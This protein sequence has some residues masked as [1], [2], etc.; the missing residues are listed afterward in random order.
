MLMAFGNIDVELSVERRVEVRPVLLALQ[1][2]VGIRGDD[3]VG[4]VPGVRLDSHR[5]GLLSRPCQR[6]LGPTGR[7]SAGA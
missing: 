7:R 4:L 6:R 2:R 1:T 3:D 5:S